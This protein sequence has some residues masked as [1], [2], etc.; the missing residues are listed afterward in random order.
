M[1]DGEDQ[2]AVLRSGFVFASRVFVEVFPILLLAASFTP[3][4]SNCQAV[5][6][7]GAYYYPWYGTFAGGHGFTDTLRY[8]LSPQQSPAI[9]YYNE[10]TASTVSAH[11]DQSHRGNISYWAVSWWG[12]NSAEDIT[13]RNYILPH[14]RAAE[15][16]YSIMYE[17]TNRL[18]SF[19][20]PNFSKLLPDFQYMAQTIFNN[21]NYLK[22]DGR[23]V[24]YIYLT[25]AYFNSQAGRDAVA[26]LR[27]S[28]KSQYGYDPY[29]VG[30]D[31]FGS[32]AVDNTRAALWDAITDYDVYGTTLQPNGSTSA[33]LNSL[34]SSFQNWKSAANRIGVGFVPSATP[35]FNDSAVRSGHPAAPRYLPGQAEGSLFES[36]LAQA[37]VPNIDPSAANMMM[38]TSFN[39]WH[40]DTQ[41]EP[42]NLA[43]P[44]SSDT[45]GGIYA[46]GYNWTGYGNT[47]LD[48][49]AR[50]TPEP[51][52]TAPLALSVLVLSRRCP[53]RI[54][55]V[56]EASRWTCLIWFL[57]IMLAGWST[58]CEMNKP[59]S[60]R[61]PGYP[62]QWP[63][64]A[65]VGAECKGLTGAYTD[66]GTCVDEK[67][68]T[69]PVRLSGILSDQL[70][71]AE[72]TVWLEIVTNKMGWDGITF[73]T[74]RVRTASSQKPTELMAF[75][76]PQALA[77]PDVR[78]ASTVVP[79]LLLN[80]SQQNL[81]LM[82]GA[83][84]SLLVKVWTYSTG[85]VV[86]AP[87]YKQSCIWARFEPA[88]TSSSLK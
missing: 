54:R 20:S 1:P 42:T 58:G 39:E 31:V 15:M 70:P 76:W 64:M 53:A 8:R 77:C 71:A 69:H 16:K 61:E 62:T 86:V 38:I 19:A 65:S 74:L 82:K 13:L 33:A 25:R 3:L 9:G 63:D 26:N 37:T 30:D 67:S 5:P 87:Y 22:I 46:Q 10:R 32:A 50:Q 88:A 45:G 34:G 79:Y 73:S 55:P 21:P 49:L 57:L 12:P 83:D 51:S 60:N 52:L 2:M 35:G 17:S 18:G 11:I 75:G 84:G 29:I 27:G 4:G 47:Y 68:V 43:G 7:V 44:T 59:P 14:P 24:V 78:S 23:P 85:A 41:I 72:G 80:A 40:E 6:L 56:R 36:M 66:E 28:I 81:W 48:L